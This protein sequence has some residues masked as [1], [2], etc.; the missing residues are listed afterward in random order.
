MARSKCLSR[1]ACR[2][3]SLAALFALMQVSA[4]AQYTFTIWNPP[5][6][7]STFQ[8]NI[9]NNG[10]IAGTSV[11]ASG[12]YFGFVRAV[13]GTFNT[14]TLPAPCPEHGCEALITGL[15]DLGQ[16]V[17]FV[18]NNASMTVVDFMRDQNGTITQLSGPPGVQFWTPGGLTNAGE[19]TAQ[20]LVFSQSMGFFYS[21]AQAFLRTSAGTYTPLP[22]PPGLFSTYFVSLNNQGE[23]IGT[24][25]TSSDLE[26]PNI[27]FILNAASSEFVFFPPFW[28][29]AALNDA[30]TVIG[31]QLLQ[32]QR[33]SFLAAPDGSILQTFYPAVPEVAFGEDGPN[34]IN[35]SGM[36]VGGFL[37]TFAAI[38]A[39]LAV[40]TSN[41]PAPTVSVIGVTGQQ[42]V[43]S[44]VDPIAG[45]YAVYPV[46]DGCSATV[47]PFTPGQKT[48][49]TVTA[50]KYTGTTHATVEITAVNPTGNSTQF[51]PDF[52]T[53]YGD[54]AP[55]NVLSGIS[56]AEHVLTVA[57]GNP[58]LS[59]LTIQLPRRKLVLPLRAN[60][61]RTLNLGR[62][63]TSSGMTSGTNTIVFSGDGPPGSEGSITLADPSPS[64]RRTLR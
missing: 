23:I 15:N 25:Q 53:V 54:G 31:Y 47:S 37:P 61:T 36:I 2:S 1:V 60:E 57:N 29:L 46:C 49:V 44:V 22:Q 64:T 6:A 35:Q 33:L 13:D 55:P 45:L 17:G 52:A 9:N 24:G 14:F 42:A 21:A 10:V 48:P 34:G 19:T 43:F 5:G 20:V 38:S 12:Q 51:D 27:S 56:S 4:A 40:P 18:Q 58:G 8:T 3:F 39:Y 62:W 11:D 30:G 32:N 7:V 50:T 63:M 59:S 16:M 41:V 26:A 28:R